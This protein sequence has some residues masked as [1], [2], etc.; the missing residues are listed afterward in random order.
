MY[1]ILITLNY[2]SNLFNLKLDN[3]R[4]ILINSRWLMWNWMYEHKKITKVWER[5]AN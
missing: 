2:F 5:I 3:Y 1:P 4:I